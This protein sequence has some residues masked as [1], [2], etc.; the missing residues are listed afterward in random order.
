MP[1]M[2]ANAPLQV[3]RISSRCQHLSVI[4]CFQ[5]NGMAAI[6]MF[7]YMLA[8]S[9]NIGK[10]S[11]TNFI[12]LYNRSLRI[13]GSMIFRKRQYLRRPTGDRLKGSKRHIERIVIVQMGL[14]DSAR[15]AIYRQLV[16][17]RQYPHTPDMVTMLVRDEKGFYFFHR[18]PQSIHAPLCFTTTNASIYQN[19]FI[20]IANIEAVAIATGIK[21]CNI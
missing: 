19:G 8:G 13:V 7:D 2:A 11:D 14:T 6:E 12:L 4:V 16:L 5:K 17:L 20:F 21:R 3:K 9:S 10:N 18:K 1:K 15:G